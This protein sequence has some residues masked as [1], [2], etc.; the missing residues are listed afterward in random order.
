M[1]GGWIER[2]L[3]DRYRSWKVIVMALLYLSLAFYFRE[4]NPEKGAQWQR[5]V[6]RAASAEAYKGEEVSLTH[7]IVGRI[8][9]GDRGAVLEVGWPKLEVTVLGLRGVE[10][11]DRIDLSGPFIDG[12]TMGIS[13][14]RIHK[15]SHRVKV[16]VSLAAAL[17]ALVIFLR[18]FRISFKGGPVI[19]PRD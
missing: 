15:G 2:F 3:S 14:L 18:A 12:N 19:R 9:D 17:A 8:L 4:A 16:W 6:F 5:V 13:D 1:T 10:P 11:G 7:A